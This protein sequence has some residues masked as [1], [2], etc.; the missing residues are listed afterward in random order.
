MLCFQTGEKPFV[1]SICGK[2]FGYRY[3]RDVH[4][5]LHSKD[6]INAINIHK[7]TMC[8]SSFARKAKLK[9]HMQKTHGTTIPHYLIENKLDTNYVKGRSLGDSV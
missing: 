1:C 4:E 7:C 3:N 5:K 6:G 2:T 8:T 9:E